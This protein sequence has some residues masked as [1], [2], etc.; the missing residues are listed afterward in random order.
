MGIALYVLVSA[1]TMQRL[2]A[3]QL[4]GT[5]ATLQMMLLA[6][7]FATEAFADLAVV[8]ALLSTGSTVAYAHFM[9][10]WL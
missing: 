7:A 8:M 10:R 5:L 2:I 3:L 9:E 1:G 4:I 6:V